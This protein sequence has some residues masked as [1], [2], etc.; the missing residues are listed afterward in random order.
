MCWQP[1]KASLLFA[2]VPWERVWLG[3]T[4]TGERQ[5]RADEPSSSR[6]PASPHPCPSGGKFSASSV[7]WRPHFPLMRCFLGCNSDKLAS[8]ERKPEGKSS[9]S[10]RLL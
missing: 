5:R 7:F 2:Q 1:E 4:T 10:F 6:T 8:V 3:K 9:Q